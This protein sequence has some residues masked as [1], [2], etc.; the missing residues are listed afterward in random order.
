MKRP[1][2]DS[3]E[4]YLRLQQERE[5]MPG[6]TNAELAERLLNECRLELFYRHED[7]PIFEPR[8]EGNDE[9]P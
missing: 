7:S 6:E 1:E 9:W 2:W 4:A 8:K 5:L 3:W